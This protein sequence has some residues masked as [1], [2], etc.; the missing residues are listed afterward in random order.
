MTLFSD[1]ID[2]YLNLSAGVSSGSK[3][4]LNDYKGQYPMPNE[5]ARYAEVQIGDM[6]V[7]KTINSITNDMKNFVTKSDIVPSQNNSGYA[8]NA[9]TAT[10]AYASLGLANSLYSI[11][12][13]QNNEWAIY[14]TD[15]QNGSILTTGNLP[16]SSTNT[17]YVLNAENATNLRDDA[18]GSIIEGTASG[19]VVTNEMTKKSSALVPDGSNFATEEYVD[20]YFLDVISV[21]NTTFSNAVLSVGLNIDTNSVAVLNEIASTF[22][23]FPIEGTATTVGGLLAALAAAVAWLKKKTGEIEAN[24]GVANA[25]LEEVA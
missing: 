20:G 8:K 9:D 25:A 10:T 1:S 5:E 15:K 6:P 24:V 14:G 22:G 17:G 18:V 7:R 4:Y 23:G 12:I 13:N 19:F 11:G 16:I 21:T 2:F 3:F